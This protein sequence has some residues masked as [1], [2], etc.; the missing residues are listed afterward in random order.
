[1]YTSRLIIIIPLYFYGGVAFGQLDTLS[2]IK[3]YAQSCPENVTSN[4]LSWISPDY[5][6]FYQQNLS[7][8]YLRA[9]HWLGISFFESWNTAQ[10][11]SL[12]QSINASR[13]TLTDQKIVLLHIPENSRIFIWGDLNGAFHS[14]MRGLDYLFDQG[15]IDD[16]LK[17]IQKNH[18]FIFNGDAL[19]R[20][21]YAL[22]TLT[23]LMNL[24][25]KN[26]ES[27]FYVRGKTESNQNWHNGQLR[28]ELKIRASHAFEK[29]IPFNTELSDFFNTLP[30]AVYAALVENP[31]DIIRISYFDRS[32][33]ILNE[34]EL[35]GDADV[36]VVI[37]AENW[38]EGI[39]TETGLGLQNQ[40]YGATAWSVF[41]SP[42][43]V[44]QEQLN[45]FYDAF[46]VID[47]KKTI[48]DSLISIVNRDV[49]KNDEFKVANQYRLVTG[50]P[51]GTPAFEQ[52]VKGELWIA[53]TMSLIA[54]IAAKGKAIQNGML[55]CINEQNSNGG[56]NNTLLRVKIKNDD[57]VAYKAKDNVH[58]FLEEDKVN[59][60]LLPIGSPT[61][62]TYLNEV[63]T[64]QCFV[65]FPVAGSSEFNVAD[66]KGIIN[67]RATYVD[68]V[69]MLIK[70]ILT[71]YGVS[72]FAFFYQ[73]DA[74]GQNP[75]EAAHELLKQKG[76]TNWIDVPYNRSGIDFKSHAR[77][78][79][80][81]EPDAIGFFSTDQ[82]TR[83][84]INEIGVPLLT[85]MHLFAVSFLEDPPFQVFMQNKGLPIMFGA[86]VPN[87]EIAD[88]EI[89]KEYRA[90][91]DKNDIF[92]ETSSLES[93]V[94]TRLFIHALQSIDAPY[95]NEKIMAYFESLT[96]FN[97]KGLN[98]SFDPTKRSLA[99]NLW[100]DI[101]KNVIWPEYSIKK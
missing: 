22:E 75:L 66:L 94:A 51:K 28:S 8:W 15:V 69:Q 26:P 53:S 14:L 7:I 5:S 90:L 73:D 92:Y 6:S 56:I 34:K 25:Y 2:A 39:R 29:A 49:R 13:K 47:F 64:K 88:I 61:L 40:Q 38:R 45:F 63:R 70:N 33:K 60:F 62:V 32:N 19:N 50:A 65:F 46:A 30:L 43:P 87:P 93:Y 37:A 31:S 10:F 12:L 1:M 79:I 35:I 4:N 27:I 81:S 24:L 72:K 41:S 98:F 101:G 55:T 68:E 96:N 86:T 84:L 67:C 77:K 11:K 17:I 20:S 44:H 58:E 91:M 89:V 23:V 99:C 52:P 95:T 57:Y 78:I 18:Y 76:I 16:N 36:K 74:Y 83:K 82:A 100:L 42:V 9:F 71:K 59:L 97:F 48:N 80:E 54:G 85:N 21:A 3:K